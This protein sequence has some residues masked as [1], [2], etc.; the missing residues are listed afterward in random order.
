MEQNIEENQEVTNVTMSAGSANIFALFIFLPIFILFGLPVIALWGWD[1]FKVGAL[2]FIGQKGQ[3]ILT[4]LVGVV[5]HEVIHGF[6]WARY[7]QHGIKSIKFG[8]KWSYL[9]PYAHCKEPLKVSQ[10][11][12]GGALPGIIL[13]ILPAILGIITGNTWLIFFGIFFTGAAGGDI[14]VLWKLRNYNDTYTIQDHPT[15]IG[16]MVMKDKPLTNENNE[17]ITL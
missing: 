4:I 10:Y 16:F 15:E 9:T 14:L 13:G 5:V 2:H 17:K 3:L 1:V 7:T 11:S 6:T 12:I 8:V